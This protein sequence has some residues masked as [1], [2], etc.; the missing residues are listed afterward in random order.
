M[1]TPVVP[2]PRRRSSR[3]IVVF[4]EWWP[5]VRTSCWR[6]AHG[7]CA[8][9]FR[10]I[11]AAGCALSA[12]TPTR[13]AVPQVT[14]NPNGLSQRLTFVSSGNL[15]GPEGTPTGRSPVTEGPVTHRRR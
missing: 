9:R 6:P 8:P 12:C 13:P 15:R 14:V 5:I 3:L 10:L 2:V 4:L 11:L 7:R 1:S